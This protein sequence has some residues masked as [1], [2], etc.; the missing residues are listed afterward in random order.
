MG[1]V[2][3]WATIM[4]LSGLL[5]GLLE[6]PTFARAARAE[7]PPGSVVTP[8]EAIPFLAAGM[9]RQRLVLAVTAT[10]RQAEDLAAAASS[11]IGP[12]RVAVLPAWETLP[13]ERLSPSSDTVGRRLAVLRRLAHPDPADETIGALDLVVAPIRAL[14]QPIVTGLGEVLPVSVHPGDEVAHDELAETLVNLGYAATD[15]VEKRGQFAIRGCILD[16][17]PPTEEH[18]LRV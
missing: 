8:D 4:D 12:H 11:L 5:P 2:G 9:A 17:F 13:H 15:L 6:D 1:G 18:P 14:L 7:G 16:V 10:T 3:E